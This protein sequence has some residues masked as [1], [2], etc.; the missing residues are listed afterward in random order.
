MKILRGYKD[1]GAEKLPKRKEFLLR[2]KK[3][4]Y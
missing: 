3:T 2:G 1:G 4:P